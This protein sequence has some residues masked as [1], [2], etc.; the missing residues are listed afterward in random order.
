MGFMGF[1]W[2]LVCQLGWLSG[3]LWIELFLLMHR[4]YDKQEMLGILRLCGMYGIGA[5]FGCHSM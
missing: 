2:A 4:D 5:F 3:I 1:V